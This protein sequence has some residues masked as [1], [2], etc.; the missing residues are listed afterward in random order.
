M[1]LLNKYDFLADIQFIDYW[2]ANSLLNDKAVAFIADIQFVDY[3][4]TEFFLKK[5]KY[6]GS[7]NNWNTYIKFT[8]KDPFAQ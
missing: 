2:E 8:K 3:W 7:L 6:D 5:S 1:K 4:D